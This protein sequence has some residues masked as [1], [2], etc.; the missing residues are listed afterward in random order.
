[1]PLTEHDLQKSLK[2]ACS[3]EETAPK[4]KH[5]RTCIV[6][7]WDNKSA[8][9][10]FRILKSQPFINDEVQLFKML[11]LIHKIIQEGHPSAL[12][13]AIREKQWIKS[14]ARIHSNA[15]HSS[16][17]KLIK[18]YITYLTNKLNFH[19]QHKGFQNGTFE[20]QE[21]VSLVSV[22]DPD[23]GYETILDLMTLMDRIDDYSQFLFASI[24][25]ETRNNEC[26]IAS[27]IPMVAESYGIYKFVTS[28]LRAMYRQL[29][30][31]DPALDP[32][33]ERYELQHARL[34]EFYAD[35][36]SW[37][38]IHTLLYIK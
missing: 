17:S 28:M 12:K 34:F 37:I 11:I 33:R 38:N 4:R 23:E 20:Y 21:Y 13:E 1:M 32:L 22:A 24:Q 6:Y 35:C 5:V 10:I 9:L 19:S 31:D 8:K 36:S 16:Y 29:G 15:A 27:L 14:L 2:K 30:E 3:I 25:S 26:R 7:T 18:E